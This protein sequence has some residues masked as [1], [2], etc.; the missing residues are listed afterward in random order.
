MSWDIDSWVIPTSETIGTTAVKVLSK[1]AL[2]SGYRIASLESNTG[3]IHHGYDSRVS[4]TS[5]DRIQPGGMLQDA[6]EWQTVHHGEV[7]LIS[8]V[9]DQE[10]TIE[11][12]VCTRK[13]P[14]WQKRKWWEGFAW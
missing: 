13:P 7:W 14:G 1:E 4:A 5:I 3:N 10:V 6:G 9:E 12:I 2:R 11:R 8:T